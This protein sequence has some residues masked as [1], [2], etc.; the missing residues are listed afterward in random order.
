VE[1]PETGP[2]WAWVP[3]MLARTPT[4]APHSYRRKVWAVISVV[5]AVRPATSVM[6]WPPGFNAV[7]E[8]TASRHGDE[9][10]PAG[11]GVSLVGNIVGFGLAHSVRSTA[12]ML[13]RLSRLSFRSRW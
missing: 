4:P 7:C 9:E 11:A 6:S 5:P 2:T 10:T 12:A 8:R 1:P 3:P 13:A